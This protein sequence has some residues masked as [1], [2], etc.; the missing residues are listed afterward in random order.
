M[1]QLAAWVREA[2]ERDTIRVLSEKTGIGTGTLS[3][4]ANNQ[5]KE[6]PEL[7]TLMRLALGLKRPLADIVEAAGIDLGLPD[8]GDA[9]LARLR[10]QA[11]H[12]PQMG[13]ILALLLQADE[14]D[15]GRLWCAHT[16]VAATTRRIQTE[17]D[18]P[19]RIMIRGRPVK[20]FNARVSLPR[21][22]MSPRLD[23]ASPVLL[24]FV[25]YRIVRRGCDTLTLCSCCRPGGRAV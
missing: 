12:D 13:E 24:V 6:K 10:A 23:A 8:D 22:G 19:I 25:S 20:A 14:A 16:C 15:E 17:Q 11:D 3:R 7:E 21:P 5:L 9:I 4:I 18:T 2:T 1:E